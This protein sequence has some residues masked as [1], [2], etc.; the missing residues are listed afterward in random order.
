MRFLV[1][2]ISIICW[3]RGTAQISDDSLNLEIVLQDV[4]IR[5]N[6]ISRM[7]MTS[8]TAWAAGNMVAS[9]IAYG[10][11]QGQVR[12]FNQMNVFWNIVNLGI[13]VPGLIGTYKHKPMNFEETI[14]YQN[15]L[16]KIYLFNAG[17]DVGYMATG[18]ALNNFGKTKTG[19]LG[20]RIKGYGNS[21]VMQGAYL[22]VHDIINLLLYR[23]NNKRLNII[24]RNITID[25]PV[26]GRMVIHF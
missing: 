14:K 24:W 8:L 2:L 22:F 16:E 18:W 13:G 19:D 4:Q 3:Q 9:G 20:E 7:A 21:L 25:P 5:Q 26:T 6:N 10:Q 17:L 12:Y 15:R 11:T 1:L 23:T